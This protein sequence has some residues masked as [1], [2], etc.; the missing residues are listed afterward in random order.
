[1]TESGS[2]IAVSTPLTI[3]V[4]QNPGTPSISPVGPTT[5]C[6]G[7]S[8]NFTAPTGYSYAWSTGETTQSINVSQTGNYTLTI[9]DVNSCSAVSTATAVTVNTLPV[10]L[11]SGNADTV[12]SNTGI[13]NLT[14]ESPSGGTFS[15]TGVNGN[16]F[17][18]ST[19]GIG[20]QIVTYSFTDNNGCIN[21]ASET[22]QVVTC[23]GINEL[24]D[25]Q[26]TVMP[27][28]SSGIFTIEFNNAAN[29]RW[30]EVMDMSGKLVYESAIA[31]AVTPIELGLISSGC[32]LLEI[33]TGTSTTHRKLLIEK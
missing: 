19:A 30:I 28:P 22:I 25:E 21:T 6:E 9:T 15:G 17:N 16:S 27:N 29:G 13:I 33:K 32:Y 23:T 14:G 18:P 24:T 10:V 3:T 4:N 11:L 5:F 12:C 2:C 31:N 7:G 20:N 26:L 8:V 1:V